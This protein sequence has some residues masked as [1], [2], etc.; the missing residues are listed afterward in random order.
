LGFAAAFLDIFFG[1][2]FDFAGAAGLGGCFS[3]FALVAGFAG[4]AAFS[5]ALAAVATVG[6]GWP[7]AFFP[8]AG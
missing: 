1:V 3:A 2:A 7:F 6:A 5:G 8:A 4:A